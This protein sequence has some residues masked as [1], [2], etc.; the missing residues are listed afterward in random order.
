MLLCIVNPSPKI[1][2]LTKVVWR[3]ILIDLWSNIKFS[4]WFTLIPGKFGGESWSLSIS[5]AFISGTLLVTGDRHSCNQV[6]VLFYKTCYNSQI[7]FAV[8]LNS[9][10]RMS[11][12]IRRNS[13]SVSS[14]PTHPQA[15]VDILNI[16]KKKF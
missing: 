8:G 11:H 5:W 6:T 9:S 2:V 3:K 1:V 10:K 4:T 15:K 16:N 12:Q 14:S 7:F 13:N